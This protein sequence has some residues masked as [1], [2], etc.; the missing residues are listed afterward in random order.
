LGP[1]IVLR[2]VI[3]ASED[4][5]NSTFD[6]LLL[7]LCHMIGGGGVSAHPVLPAA[8][9]AICIIRFIFFLDAA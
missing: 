9:I 1:G 3:T 8:I 6:P 2:S 7:I 5:R 4:E